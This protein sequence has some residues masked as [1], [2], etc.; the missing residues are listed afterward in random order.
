MFDE[1]VEAG[2][3]ASRVRKGAVKKVHAGM[4]VF[5]LVEWVESEIRSAGAGLAFPCNVS[6]NDIA[7]HYTSS[8]VDDTLLCEGDLVKI[9]L[10]SHVNGFVSDSAVSVVVEGNNVDCVDVDG[11]PLFMPGRLDEGN[12]V[13]G[14]D[15]LAERE[16]LVEST[17]AA[18]EN[19]LSILCD[20]VSVGDIGRVVEDT[21]SSYGFKSVVNL[22]GHS[23]GRFKLHGGVSIP[24]CRVDDSVCLSE[25]DC[26][27]IEPYATCGIGHVVDVPLYNIFSYLRNR[28][29]RSAESSLL[30][31][32]VR[33]D[34]TYFPFASRHLFDGSMGLDE[35]NVAFK[36][37]VS[38]RAVFPYPVCREQSG[39]VVAQS[40]HT[41]IV[42]K[43]SCFV[44][45]L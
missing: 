14:G 28:P 1:L 29:F 7:S 10:G 40:E 13:V 22:S 11:N 32:R 9:D 17:E 12:P 31:R 15:V 34:F 35:F 36:P 45:T 26:V 6:I 44:T 4:R 39:C 33:E 24:N 20:G 30:L 43:D 23:I 25:G 8:V 19:A 27:A 41:V 21:I 37:L 18:L 5:D 16:L 42:E 2:R 3:I 38:S